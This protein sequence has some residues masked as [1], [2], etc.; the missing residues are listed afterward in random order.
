MSEADVN[1]IE[2]LLNRLIAA[3]EERCPQRQRIIEAQGEDLDEAFS[4]IRN[5]ESKVTRL[6]VV[7]ALVTPIITA[8]LIQFFV[9]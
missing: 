2:L 1:K 6:T 3:L 8:A 9:R 4:R 7:S 5:L